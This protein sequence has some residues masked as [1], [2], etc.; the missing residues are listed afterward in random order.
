[1]KRTIT[2]ALAGIV[3]GGMAAGFAGTVA[4]QEKVTYLFPAPPMLPA[5][6]PIRIAQGKGYFKAEGFDVQFQVAKGGVDVAKQIGAGNAP[7]GGILG[8]GP[9]LVRPQGIPMKGVALFGGRGFMQLVVREDSGV[10]DPKGL[11]GKD[12]SVMAFQDTTYFVLQ[13][14]LARVGLSIKDVNAQAAGPVGVWQLVASGKAIACACVPDWIPLITATG[15]KVKV[16]Q[17]FDYFPSMA[18]GIGTSD[19]IIAANP[20]MVQ[21]F[22]RAAL[23]GMKDIMDDPK[24]AADDFVT[25][26]PEWKG[27]NAV[28]ASVFKYYAE[29]VY[30]GQPKL[31]MFDPARVAAVQD[32][33]VKQKIIPSGSKVEDLF[34]NQFV[35]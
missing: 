12:I 1:M 4:A 2:T 16:I 34:T 18:Q 9:I 20:Q 25:Y 3:A 21:K 17:S 27:K 19:K 23:K 13:G 22:V 31:G 33:Y 6:G 10:T 26:V 7:F 28:I 24:K 15:T 32:F 35:Q 5:F 14:V 8:D 29:L 11:K 30:P